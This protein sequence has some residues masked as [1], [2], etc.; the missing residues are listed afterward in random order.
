MFPVSF[1]RSKVPVAGTAHEHCRELHTTPRLLIRGALG[2]EE[3]IKGFSGEQI[4]YTNRT[5]LVP[6]S[7]SPLSPLRHP[8]SGVAR[9]NPSLMQNQTT[10]EVEPFRAEREV[11]FRIRWPRQEMRPV[12]RGSLQSQASWPPELHLNWR[13]SLTCSARQPPL[14]GYS[15]PL[16]LRRAD[17]RESLPG[18]SLSSP[19]RRQAPSPPISH[20]A[21]AS[22]AESSSSAPAVLPE[23]HTA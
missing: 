2:A 3:R 22:G 14:R 16:L 9:N 23:R 19:R 21:P 6:P 13:T 8:S 1:D 12:P 18:R 5:I 11:S 15:G 7:A 10:L 20:V 17:E 4:R